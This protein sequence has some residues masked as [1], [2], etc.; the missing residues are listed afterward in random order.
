M[1]K[2]GYLVSFLEPDDPRPPR[3]GGTTPRPPRSRA[4][5]SSDAQTLRTRRTIAGIGGVVILILLILGIKGC[6]DSQKEQQFKDFARDASAIVQ[7]SNQQS[8]AF[9]GLLR[10]DQQGQGPVDIGNAVNGYRVDAAR[11]V[12]RAKRLDPPDEMKSSLAYLREVLEFRRDGLAAIANAIPTALGDQGRSAAAQKIAAQMQ[13][14]LTSDVVYSQKL[15]PAE[16]NA[17]KSEGLLGTVEVPKSQFLP[18]IDW[19]RP[20]TVADQLGSLKGGGGGKKTGPV[21]PGLHG[22]GLVGVTV[23]PAGTELSADGGNT[24]TASSGLKFD[25]QIANQ[26]ENEETG[27]KVQVSVKGGGGKA[28]TAEQT[29]D[30]IAAGE[31]KTV[32]VPLTDTPPIG[33]PVTID[34]SVEPVAGEKKTDNNKGTYQAVFSRG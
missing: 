22:T 32:S 23:Q 20:T 29:L 19:L 26:G 13:N 6:L 10:G 15:I 16:Q 12:D 9:F 11:F 24:L 17:L 8:T 34:V 14:F 33:K 21:K 2:E 25:V 18:D 1:A 30:T 5:G 3:R 27:V 31:Q 28:L 4:G 7:E